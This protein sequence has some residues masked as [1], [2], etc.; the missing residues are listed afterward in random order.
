MLTRHNP[1]PLPFCPPPSLLPTRVLRLQGEQENYQREKLPPPCTAGWTQVLVHVMPTLYQWIAPVLAMVLIRSTA[2]ACE[3][4]QVLS[5]G[6]GEIIGECHAYQWGHTDTATVMVKSTF[7]ILSY[8]R[9]TLVSES[10]PRQCQC[11][12]ITNALGDN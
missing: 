8:S 12:L 10:S 3:G 6:R 5:S 11:L 7:E 4:W 2:F 1:I 9:L